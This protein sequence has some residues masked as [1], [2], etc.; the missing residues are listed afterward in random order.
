MRHRQLHFLIEKCHRG[1]FF[2][3]GPTL[4][5]KI[6][7]LILNVVLYQRMSN[8]WAMVLLIPTGTWPL[9]T[10]TVRLPTTPAVT[11]RHTEPVFTTILAGVKN[12]EKM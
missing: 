7:Y 6:K 1:G 10:A 4:L 12:F 5:E 2:Q 9:W 3:A 11:E 8:L